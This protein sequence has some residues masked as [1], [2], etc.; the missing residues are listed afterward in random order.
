VRRSENISH[1]PSAIICRKLVS[2]FFFIQSSQNF[3]VIS[4]IK[5]LL[6]IIMEFY[7]D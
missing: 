2:S 7:S 4:T 5:I 1:Q 6:I 3:I